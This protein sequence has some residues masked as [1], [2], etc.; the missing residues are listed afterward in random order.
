MRIDLVF[1]RD[2]PHVDDA[3]ALLRAAMA[4]TGVHLQWNEWDRQSAETPFELR[5]VGSPTIL[6]NGVDVVGADAVGM[7]PDGASC[8][9]V[10]PDNGRLRGVPPLQ[11]VVSA[12]ARR[13]T[14]S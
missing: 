2:C 9:R 6:V 12:L 11:A 3:R 5:E 8:C 1:D 4:E 7:H 13:T 10:Y 14:R